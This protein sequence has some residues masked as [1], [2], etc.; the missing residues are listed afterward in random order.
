MIAQAGGDQLQHL[1]LA[2]GQLGNHLG[3]ILLVGAGEGHDAAGN[4]GALDRL[5]GWHR[6]QGPKEHRL[7]RWLYVEGDALLGGTFELVALNGPGTSP[8][9]LEH[10]RRLT[11]GTAHPKRGNVGI[12]RRCHSAVGHPKQRRD[13]Q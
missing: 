8:A 13:R 5:A 10:E 4:R 2:F 7:R 3:G 9:E 12:R 11:S 6:Q 1:P